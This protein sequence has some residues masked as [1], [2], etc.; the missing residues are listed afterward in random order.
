MRFGSRE[1]VYEAMTSG[2]GIGFM[3]VAASRRR[4]GVHLRPLRELPESYPEAVFCLRPRYQRRMVRSVCDL[5]GE[6]A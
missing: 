1:A 6:M 4:D 5:A 2:F 3:L